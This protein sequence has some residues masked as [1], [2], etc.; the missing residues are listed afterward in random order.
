MNISDN[1]VASF[2]YTLTDKEGKVL[3]SSDGREPLAYLH[4]ASN[5]IP[6]LEKEL[7]GKQVGDKLKVDVPAAEA[8]GERNDEMMQEL[9]ASMFTGV[10]KI[11]VGMEFHAQTEQGTQVVSIAAVDG[12]NVTVD[13]NHPLAGVD[14]TFDVEITDV[15]EATSEEQEHGHAHGAGGHEH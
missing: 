14:L 10:E 11:E 3:D 8:Y 13:A 15:R 5:I 2:H 6:G 4:G 9:P 7:V 1:C 12:D